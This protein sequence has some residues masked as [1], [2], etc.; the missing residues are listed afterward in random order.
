ME[1]IIFAVATLST[2]VALHHVFVGPSSNFQPSDWDF[3]DY[4]SHKL[5]SSD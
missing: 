3:A 2:L 1:L 5:A 4:W